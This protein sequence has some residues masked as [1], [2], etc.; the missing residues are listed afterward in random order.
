MMRCGSIRASASSPNKWASKDTER[1]NLDVNA[2]YLV[3]GGIS[4]AFTSIIVYIFFRTKHELSGKQIT[5]IFLLG[6]VGV[7]GY[8]VVATYFGWSLTETI[9]AMLG[10][11]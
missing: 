4:L 7:R 1:N 10:I 11:P 3:G 6:A 8:D 2:L 9:K 5:L